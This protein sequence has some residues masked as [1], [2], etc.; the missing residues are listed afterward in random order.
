MAMLRLPTMESN[1]RANIHQGGVGVGIDLLTG[2]THH[3]IHRDQEIQRHPDT[4]ETLLDREVPS[5]PE[6]LQLSRRIARAV[7][8]GFLGVDIVLDALHGPMLLEANARPGLAIQLAND[9]GLLHSMIEID[10]GA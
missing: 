4:G 3:A 10:R 9:A 1:G 5:W 8:L 2:L 6:I 7:G